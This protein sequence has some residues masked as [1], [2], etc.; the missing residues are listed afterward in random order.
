MSTDLVSIVLDPLTVMR[1]KNFAFGGPLAVGYNEE[2]LSAEKSTLLESLLSVAVNYANIN[3]DIESATTE[4]PVAC[5][6][7]Y[8]FEEFDTIY[9]RNDFSKFSFYDYND[10]PDSY[11]VEEQYNHALEE[12]ALGIR[13]ILANNGLYRY[14]LAENIRSAIPVS[15]W[16]LSRFLV[17]G[18][19]TIVL[20]LEDNKMASEFAN[21]F[22]GDL[23][24]IPFGVVY[25][26][27]T[28]T[29]SELVYYSSTHGRR[30]YDAIQTSQHA[31]SGINHTNFGNAGTL[32]T[33][34]KFCFG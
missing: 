29:Y 22:F 10:N 16:F 15:T 32:K 3:T 23:D 30:I 9:Y 13:D 11:D 25:E 5:S 19:N 7:T 24:D 6:C 4:E 2:N 8:V 12:I 26:P 1:I 17:A 27:N 14:Y 20:Y 28:K 31:S 18:D 33:P 21:E 34:A